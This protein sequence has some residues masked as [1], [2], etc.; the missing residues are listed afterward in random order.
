VR[1][2]IPPG[3]TLL[4]LLLLL[5]GFGMAAVCL[6]GADME[7][8]GWA[9]SALAPVHLV[10]AGESSPVTDGDPNTDVVIPNDGGDG[11]PGSDADTSAPFSGGICGSV[12]V[13]S[14]G[15]EAVVPAAGIPVFLYREGVLQPVSVARTDAEG[16]Y[17]FEYDADPQD[18]YAVEAA[19]CTDRV[20]IVDAEGGSFT[21]LA[22]RSPSEGF[23]GMTPAGLR[24]DLVFDDADAVADYLLA[25]SIVENIDAAHAFVAVTF[26]Y[27]APQVTVRIHCPEVTVPEHLSGTLSFGTAERS[28]PVPDGDQVWHEFGH[29]VHYFNTEPHT[30]KLA[31]NRS[32]KEGWA[33]YFGY[34]L[35][36]D[37]APGFDTEPNRNFG[38]TDPRYSADIR[39]GMV[40][41]GIFR[42]LADGADPADADACDGG[43]SGGGR[44][45]WTVIMESD[46]EDM[47]AFFER[48]VDP[49]DTAAVRAATTVY[50]AHGLIAPVCRGR[51]EGVCTVIPTG[52]PETTGVLA[53]NATV[54]NLADA[55]LDF[56]LQCSLFGR[57][58]T[59]LS[60][61]TIG[62][63]RLCCLSPGDTGVTLSQRIPLDLPEGTSRGILALVPRAYNNACEQNGT[64]FLN[65]QDAIDTLEVSF[66]VTGRG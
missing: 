18:R 61:T 22:V 43:L 60:C 10:S 64:R 23:R 21:A 1:G 31:V 32:F 42:D 39:L 40:Y 25:R 50:A 15:E 3:G 28:Y 27:A 36:P 49:D 56:E 4:F 37:E 65:S 20:R 7:G 58:G 26:G 51:L 9:P 38:Q 55:P 12:G 17:C 24:E 47:S 45:I 52:N 2:A 59:L 5:A 44:A 66:A 57:N 14:G 33:C 34:D 54:V 48:F 8:G 41:A 46:P 35:S 13:S 6:P 63:E 30:W 62:E 29:A 53:I 16:R 11:G 19:W